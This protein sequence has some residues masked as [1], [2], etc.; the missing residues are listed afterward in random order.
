MS[1]V[2]DGI[3][4]MLFDYIVNL[5]AETPICRLLG[6]EMIRIGVG[7]AEIRLLAAEK[8]GNT[9]GGVQGGVLMTLADAAMGTA[10]RSMGFIGATV[11][12]SSHFFSPTGPGQLL[13]AKADFVKKSGK[14][15]F[16]TAE[17]SSEDKVLYRSQGIFYMIGEFEKLIPLCVE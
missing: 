12:M 10:V 6:M 14:L 2:N 9:R 17:I 16:A 4:P 7:T 5:M 11:E 15:L 1:A 8:H 13:I 3:N